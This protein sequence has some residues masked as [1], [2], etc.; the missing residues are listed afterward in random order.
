MSID[1]NSVF[2]VTDQFS[3]SLPYVSSVLFVASPTKSPSPPTQPSKQKQADV[4]YTQSI[5][6]TSISQSQSKQHA[7][8]SP[9]SQLASSI[10]VSM[11][12]RAPLSPDRKRRLSEAFSLVCL[13]KDQNK[14]AGDQKRKKPDERKIPARELK[15]RLEAIFAATV[16]QPK[17]TENEANR[18]NGL[19]IVTNKVHWSNSLFT[20][21]THQ[22]DYRYSDTGSEKL[23]ADPL[24]AEDDDIIPQVVSNSSDTDR[25]RAVAG[26]LLPSA[27]KNRPFIS[28]TGPL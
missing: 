22:P 13:D 12:G 15:A 9:I 14:C 11:V 6:T 21:S 8:P 23:V 4:R 27:G 10:P 1:M 16:S 17:M 28:V 7:L 24:V 20:A 25:K 18:H 5:L 19:H 3:G 26:K 2:P